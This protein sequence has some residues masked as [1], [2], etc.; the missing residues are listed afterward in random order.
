MKYSSD[1]VLLATF[2]SPFRSLFPNWRHFRFSASGHFRRSYRLAILLPQEAVANVKTT[3]A[4]LP[5]ATATGPFQS[6]DVTRTSSIRV[7]SLKADGWLFREWPFPRRRRHMLRCL[8][9]GRIM[10]PANFTLV[11][12]DYRRSCEMQMKRRRRPRLSKP[13]Q[14]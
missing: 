12:A 5:V 7:F 4:T 2:C 14:T 13:E 8:I 3:P 6:G 10:R 11:L 9:Y 1:L